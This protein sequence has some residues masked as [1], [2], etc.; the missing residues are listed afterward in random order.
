MSEGFKLASTG[1]DGKIYFV[2]LTYYCWG[3]HYRPSIFEENGWTPP[4]TMDEL[5]ALAEK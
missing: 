4:T 2:P 3:I 1:Q 5:M